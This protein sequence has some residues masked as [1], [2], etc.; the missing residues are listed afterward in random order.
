MES[1]KRYD[2][3]AVRTGLSLYVFD[4]P[5]SPEHHGYAEVSKPYG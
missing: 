5:R 1:E 4:P 3:E 2:V